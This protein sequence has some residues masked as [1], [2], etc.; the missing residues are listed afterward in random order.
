MYALAVKKSGKVAEFGIWED[1][2]WAWNVQFRRQLFDWEVEQWEQFHDNFKEFHFCKDFKDE[3]VWKRETSGNYTTKSFCRYVHVSNENVDRVWNYVWANLAPFRIEVFM[4]QLLQGKIGVKDELA[5]RGV[6]LKNM[7]QCAL[8]NVIRETCDHLFITCR[9]SWK[10][11]M[12]WCRM[13]GMG[14]VLPSNVKDLFAMWNEWQ[15]GGKEWNTDQVLELARIR[16][17]T[18]VNAKW[19]REY[20]SALNVYRQPTIQCQLPKKGQERKGIQWD[21]P[22]YGQMK[23]NVDGAARGCPRPTGIGGI[24]RDHRGEVKI[25]FSKPISET[26]SNFAE[27][28]AIKEAFLIFS[29]SRWKNNHKLLIES[30]SSNAVKWIKHPDGA[31]WRMRKLIL[32]TKKL[33]RE[34]EGWEIQHVRREAN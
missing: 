6:N 10:V 3:H 9:K 13:W 25:I 24:L 16:V 17:A 19:P 32:Q 28:M 23:F 33:K 7:L 1:G 5:K 27:M 4:W 14:W 21:K 15:L 20:P 30:D 2:R 8:C 22:R 26:D 31:P 11:W 18:W 12:G 29:V 34:V